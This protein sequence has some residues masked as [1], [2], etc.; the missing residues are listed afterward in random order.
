MAT[1]NLF[2]TEQVF[3]PTTCQYLAQII[4]KHNEYGQSNKDSTS[5]GAKMNGFGVKT[6]ATP[7]F[8]LKNFVEHMVCT[9]ELEGFQLNRAPNTLQ[10]S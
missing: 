6:Q 5:M 4:R 3:D 7:R 2:P 8:S 9:T 1:T 10:G